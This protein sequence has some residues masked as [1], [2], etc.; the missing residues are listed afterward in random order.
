[1][2]RGGY[3]NNEKASFQRGGWLAVFAQQHDIEA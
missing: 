3:N 1:M 2:R